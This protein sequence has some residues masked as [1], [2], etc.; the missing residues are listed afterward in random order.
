MDAFNRFVIGLRFR[1]LLRLELRNRVREPGWVSDRARV[2]AQSNG[3]S[4][5]LGEGY[6]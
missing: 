6:C 4:Y 3:E 1:F 5:G 2:R